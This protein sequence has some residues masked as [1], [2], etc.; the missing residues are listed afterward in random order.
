M[1]FY[2][3]LA[4]LWKKAKS[5]KRRFSSNYPT[6]TD[7]VVKNLPAIQET[8]E[9]RV[10]SLGR[11]PGGW[12]GN[13]LQYSCQENPMDTG[14][15]RAAVH[16]VLKSQTQLKPLS[17]HTHARTHTHTHTHTHTQNPTGSPIYTSNNSL[18]L[19]PV[20]KAPTFY[21][22]VSSSLPSPSPIICLQTAAQTQTSKSP[23]HACFSPGPGLRIPALRLLSNR[24]QNMTPPKRKLKPSSEK[25]YLWADQALFP[26]SLT[27]TAYSW[28][29]SPSVTQMKKI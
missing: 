13:P 7:L 16:G 20:P 5:L 8:K 10:W 4:W 12:H 3:V 17:M 29:A 11:S 9:T 28:A 24:P 27:A 2:L 25:H 14:A 22:P 18:S 21:R 19:H 1:C 23:G 26:S 6:P 15:W